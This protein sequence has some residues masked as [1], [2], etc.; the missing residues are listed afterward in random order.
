[1]AAG[2]LWIVRN[3]ANVRVRKQEAPHLPWGTSGS[4]KWAHYYCLL[5]IND[6]QL[7][8]MKH[9]RASGGRARETMVWHL[10]E[11]G[12]KRMLLF[13]LKVVLSEALIQGES[14][15]GK[16][17]PRILEDHVI[18]WIAWSGFK[19]KHVGNNQ[20]WGPQWCMWLCRLK[21]KTRYR[22]RTESPRSEP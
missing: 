10:S 3:R 2:K 14:Q 22:N 7:P 5:T 17:V 19:S 18:C 11:E 4:S 20:I 15:A 9:Q 8:R 21:E 16:R 6:I 1:M 13:G 12:V